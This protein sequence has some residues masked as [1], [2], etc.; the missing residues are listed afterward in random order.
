MVLAACDEA[1]KLDE[2]NGLYYNS[3]GIALLQVGKLKEA[4]EDFAEF[5]AWLEK[6]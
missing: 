4:Q 1:I 6:Q 2:E 5:E 3:R